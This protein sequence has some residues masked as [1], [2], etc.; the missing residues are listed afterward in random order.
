MKQMPIQDALSYFDL[1]VANLPNL[2]NNQS[3]ALLNKNLIKFKEIIKKAYRRVALKNHPDV[4][5]DQE[6]MKLINEL[7]GSFMSMK[8]VPSTPMPVYVRTRRYYS[9]TNT[10]TSSTTAGWS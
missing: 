9:Y 8:I 5:G 4:G 2:G 10:T 6:R 7:Y 1:N 3:I